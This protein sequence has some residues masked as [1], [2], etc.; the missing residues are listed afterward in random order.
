V[1][2][3]NKHM[4]RADVLMSGD[5]D[6]V[7]LI[8]SLQYSRSVLSVALDG[9]RREE[10]PYQPLLRSPIF[11]FRGGDR[12]GILQNRPKSL[13]VGISGHWTHR[14]FE[15]L[16]FLVETIHLIGCRVT[17]R[18]DFT[19]KITSIIISTRTLRIDSPLLSFVVQDL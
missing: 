19:G 17:S 4:R 6:T 2:D 13:H 1:E 14:N 15:P 5:L 11:K 3:R 8:H 18:W 12:L 7:K 16:L 10:V 9:I